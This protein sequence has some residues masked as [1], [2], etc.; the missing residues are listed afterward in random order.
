MYSI[1]YIFLNMGDHF[2]LEQKQIKANQMPKNEQFPVPTP[3]DQVID[4]HQSGARISHHVLAED[5]HVL[6]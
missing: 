6:R 2:I 4:M 3:P 1:E 5:T